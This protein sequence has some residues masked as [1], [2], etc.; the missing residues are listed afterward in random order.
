MGKKKQEKEYRCNPD[1]TM[2]LRRLRERAGLTLTEAA[3]FFDVKEYE[4]VAKW[5][6]GRT[7]PPESRHRLKWIDYLLNKLNLRRNPETIQ[8]FLRTW[9]KVMCLEWEWEPLS[10]DESWQY[11]PDQLKH[12]SPA[13]FAGIPYLAPPRPDYD[14]IGRI[15]LLNQLKQRLFAGG[16]LA[17]TAL[18]GLPGI[19]KTALAIELARDPE[20][21][22]HFRDGV[23]WARLG[24]EAGEAQTLTEL[25][26]WAKAVGIASEELEN[27]TEVGTLTDA[28]KAKIGL[29]RM[30]LICDDAWQK[31]T[32][33]DFK[34]GGPNC[35]HMVTTRSRELALDFAHTGAIEIPEL[36]DPYSRTLLAAFAPQLSEDELQQLVEAVGG[37]PLGLILMG[38]YIRNNPSIPTNKTLD[39]LKKTEIRLQTLYLPVG[40]P[41]R[42]PSLPEQR[43][44]TL[45]AIINI[46]YDALEN[47]EKVTLEALSVFP[48]K[49]NTFS[50][51]AALTVTKNTT[52]ALRALVNKYGLLEPSGNRYTLH[53]TISEFSATKLT[54]ETAYQRMAE[55]FV[56]YVKTHR[57][58]YDAIELEIDNIL[59]VL[60]LAAN[61]EM[62]ALLVQGA[63]TLYHFLEN[64]GLYELAKTHLSRAEQAARALGETNDLA[65]TLF[66]LGHVAE[67]RGE[68]EETYGYYRETLPLVEK[69]GDPN[70]ISVVF[71]GLGVVAE[72][73]E[74]FAHAEGYY[75]KALELAR[76]INNPQRMSTALLNLCGLARDR[77]NLVQAEEYGQEGLALARELED[78]ENISSLL[79]NLGA[80]AGTRKNY[81]QEQEFYEEGLIVAR[82]LGHR[83]TI[84]R[85]LTNL[86]I[87]AEDQGDY[88]QAEKYC[89][90]GLVIAQEIGHQD[91]I[92]ALLRG[93]GSVR[94]FREDYEQAEEFLQQSLAIARELKDPSLTTKVLKVSGETYLRQQKFDLAKSTFSESLE[95]ARKLGGKEFIADALFGLAQIAAA[96]G[97]TVKA[98]RLGQ[99]SLALFETIIGHKK[100]DVITQWLNTLPTPESSE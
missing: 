72:H 93:L 90:E 97:D 89:Q 56:K 67:K 92:C 39:L 32:A 41:E 52:D 28:I 45:V 17:L 24:H 31:E 99:E 49:P 81:V 10:R 3:N 75:Q 60:Q 16:N 35:V 29:S 13:L 38:R 30:L 94:M 1:I 74:D 96:Q 95:I 87:L 73:L 84:A 36:N 19:G 12:I 34:V 58:D 37:L 98:R 57:T 5:E 26:K 40:R 85:L 59:E 18:N 77:G 63:N 11:I 6:L 7:I 4:T 27:L 86:G 46:S 22:N 62:P 79:L 15:D 69:T 20:V 51:P 33:L 71:Q 80:V 14:L 68:Y 64:R 61:R 76:Q 55:F 88:T 43:R 70:K 21:L 53:L 48:P 100:V 78:L 9:N 66:S 65:I 82:E 2:R 91:R 83:E 8:Q 47:H 54:D 44:L 25:N 42:H 50:E 23:L